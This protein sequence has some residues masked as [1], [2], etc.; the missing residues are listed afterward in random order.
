[1][2]KTVC[3]DQ[4]AF[5]SVELHALVSTPD[6]R[7]VVTDAALM[8]MCKNIETWERSVEMKF[9]YLARVPDRVVFV[10]GNGENM[11]SEREAE[12]PHTLESLIHWETT[13]W[14]RDLLSEIASGRKG[15]AFQMMIDNIA[16]ANQTA[17]QQY[18]D[19]EDNRDRLLGLIETFLGKEG[20]SEEF[21][22]R[23]RSHEVEEPDYIAAVSQA[24][25]TVLTQV[26]GPWSPALLHKLLDARAYSMRWLWLRVEAV[27]HWIAMGGSDSAKAKALTNDEIDS[28]YVTI[29]SYC[30]ALLT[31]DNRARQKDVRLRA[32]L[33]MKAPWHE[34][35]VA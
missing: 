21:R 16:E 17:Q 22:C 26:S 31:K 13:G 2:L 7:F 14:L 34:P 9:E 11:T 23:L 10:P 33:A 5:R 27:T 1:V 12:Q 28:Q 30:Y 25:A 18:L 15:S 20:Y 3:I 32:A 29:G 6:V 8:E 24:T 35:L 19:H 4:G